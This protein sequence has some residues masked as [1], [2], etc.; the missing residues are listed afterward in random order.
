MPEEGSRDEG[1]KMMDRI[2]AAFRKASSRI[3]WAYSL[4]IVILAL[5][6]YAVD[7]VI[8]SKDIFLLTFMSLCIDIVCTVF[9]SLED[10]KAW[11]RMPYWI[12]KLIAMPF[13]LAITIIG[14]MN[15]GFV[16]GKFRTSLMIV[17]LSFGIAYLISSVIMY[18]MEK[19]Q[20]DKMNDAL[21]LIQKEIAKEDE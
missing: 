21:S 17:V 14:I 18:Y 9:L 11:E 2:I 5:R 7:G 10:W 12:K 20:T 6:S 8:A 16:R 19:K 4:C 13:L 1:G 3:I 15:L